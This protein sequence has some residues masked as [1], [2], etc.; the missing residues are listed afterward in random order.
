[1]NRRRWRIGAMGAVLCAT[2]SFALGGPVASANPSDPSDPPS[3]HDHSSHAHAEQ[4]LADVPISQIEKQTRAAAAKIK[5]DTGNAPGGHTKTQIV[6]NAG[7]SAIA[8]A[9]PGAGGAWGGVIP[10]EVVPIFQAVL[11]NGKV[12]MW[13]SVGDNAAESYIDHTFTR[14]LVWDPTTNTSVR[15]D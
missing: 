2:L 15:R 4:D 1:M 3:D 5:H 7:L 11:P 14:A 9:D 10:T 12:L 13:D 8:A 6:P